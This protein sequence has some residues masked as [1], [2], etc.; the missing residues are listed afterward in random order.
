MYSS[1]L[2]LNSELDGVGGQRFCPA[3]LPPENSPGIHII[4]FFMFNNYIQD[5][6]NYIPNKNHVSTLYSAAVL[7]FSH[8]VLHVITHVTC[9]AYFYIT[10]FRSMFAVHR[11]AAFCSSGRCALPVCCSDIFWRI[12]RWFQLLPFLLISLLIYT[13]H[14]LHF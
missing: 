12:L 11:M 3:A 4:I 5:M 8:F 1:S 6:Y 13:P 9:V 14:M 7:L 10:T 2:Y